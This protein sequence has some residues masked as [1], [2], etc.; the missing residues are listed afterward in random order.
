M[1]H[2]AEFSLTWKGEQVFEIYKP[3]GYT[4]KDIVDTVKKITNAKKGAFSGR[5]DPMACGWLKIFL[6]DACK[7][8]NIMNLIDKTYRFIFAFDM[9]SSS[10]DLLGIPEYKQTLKGIKRSD[11]IVFLETIR[12]GNYDQRMPALSSYQV[13]NKSGEKHPL[14]WWTQNDRLEEVELPSFKKTLYDYDLVGFNSI[15][16][17]DLAELALQRI[18]LIDKKHKFNQDVIVSHW[19]QLKTLDK[20]ILTFEIKAKVSSGFY[21]RQLVKDIGVFLGIDTLTIEIERLS[22]S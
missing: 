3:F 14:W 8:A 18:H 13:S 7:R 21:I 5:L 12:G 9:K 10:G 6:D 22:Y 16:L 20:P 4:P 15:P 19:R 2:L 17:H 1:Y 11:I